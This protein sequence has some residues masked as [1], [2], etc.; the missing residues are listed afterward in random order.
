MLTDTKEHNPT[1]TSP[2]SHHK[3]YCK[4]TPYPTLGPASRGN[5]QGLPGLAINGTQ[6]S[7][8]KMQMPRPPAPKLAELD[9]LGWV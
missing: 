3:R 2:N 7:F 4:S 5:W 6:G 8:L 9:S 1:H